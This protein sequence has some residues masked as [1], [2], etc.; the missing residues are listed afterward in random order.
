MEL[1]TRAQGVYH[2]HIHS[3]LLRRQQVP[4]RAMEFGQI[5]N[6]HW[7]VRFSFC[8]AHGAYSLFPQCRGRRFDVSVF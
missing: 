8:R 4:S 7:R 1:I 5:L 6:S 2:T 3:R